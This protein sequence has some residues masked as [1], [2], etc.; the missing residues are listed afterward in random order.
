MKLFLMPLLS[1]SMLLFVAC[2][3]DE[4][5]EGS[6]GTV[7]GKG[8]FNITIDNGEVATDDSDEVYVADSRLAI[9][10]LTASFET[11]DMIGITSGELVNLQYNVVASGSGAYAV[12]EDESVADLFVLGDSVFS[13]YPYQA[14][15][16]R[17]ALFEF[18]AEQVQS[19]VEASHLVDYDVLVATPKVLKETNSLT[20]RHAVAWLEFNV[21]N[22]DLGGDTDYLKSITITT[23]EPLF[24]TKGQLNTCAGVNSS[25]YLTFTPIEMTNEIKISVAD[26]VSDWNAMDPNEYATLVMAVAPVDL[27]K[28][29]ITITAETAN[30]TK[31]LEG[32][33]VNFSAGKKYTLDIGEAYYV[34][35]TVGDLEFYVPNE[36]RDNNFN[37]DK[38]EWSYHRY[39]ESEH[40]ILFWAK[41]FG[42]NPLNAPS[43]N[44][45]SMNV[46][47]RNVIN[48][49]EN[50]YDKNINVLGFKDPEG[51]SYL[52]QYKMEIYINYDRNASY[53]ATGS[54]YDNIIGA[55]WANVD[56]CD[57]STMAHEIG[58]SFQ[59]QTYCDARISGST[60]SRT[61][62]WRYGFGKTPGSG[63]DDGCAWWE[64]CAQWQSFQV[65]PSG[66]FSGWY[67]S[68]PPNVHLHPLH[69][70]PRYSN[71]FIQDYWI[72]V[73]SADFL[74]LLW[75]QATQPEDPF[76]TYMRLTGI[77]RQQFNDEMFDYAR[78]LQ[79][80]DITHCEDNGG[81][82]YIDQFSS[83]A[84]LYDNEDGYYRISYGSAPENYGFNAIRLVAPSEATTM[85][86]ELVGLAGTTGYRN[87]SDTTGTL[88]SL[89]SAGWEFGF[90]AY[91]KST[92]TRTYGSAKSVTG[93]NGSDTVKFDCPAGC[94]YLW[95]VVMGAPT[96]YWHHAWNGTSTDDEQWPYKIKLTN[97]SLYYG[98]QSLSE[99]WDESTKTY[100]YNVGFAVNS[101]TYEVMT[102]TPDVSILAEALGLSSSTQF[103][104]NLSKMTVA[105]LNADGTTTAGTTTNTSAY[106]YWFSAN[107]SVCTWSSTVGTLYVD[108]DDFKTITLGQ[109]PGVTAAGNTYHAGY[110]IDYNGNTVK[111]SIEATTTN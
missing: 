46:N 74:G 45:M 88:W 7:T 58:H 90:V 42:D 26:G 78:R 16:D 72:M 111:I 92:K 37:S 59:Y 34:R 79:T 62:G 70:E 27:S 11:G 41:D 3:D 47:V 53:L 35:D 94:D 43:K 69:E 60:N 28:T 30:G 44:G 14:D 32:S 12:P 54:G 82:S 107:G 15:A 50:I 17:V 40:F 29:T 13:Y 80:Y 99:S 38:S 18:D 109:H 85:S 66:M 48:Y 100:N 51:P 83:Y 86:A 49:A 57:A 102:L 10:G 110:Q 20:F 68:F 76:E 89:D 5:K 61:C 52:D 77:D 71:Y 84:N 25:D 87:P 39:L 24:T 93:A 31:V 56:G 8:L 105:G 23:L 63:S 73:Q 4:L 65:Y 55:L 97:A 64:Q 106:G 91:N 98:T 95:L 9:N 67:Y 101:S 96:G 75:R 1:L 36:L 21:Y 103:S 104:N 6:S 2:A 33:A 81:T 108:T 19:D 22:E